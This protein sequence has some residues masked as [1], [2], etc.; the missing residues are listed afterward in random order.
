[1][2]TRNRTIRAV[3]RSE[4]E[5]QN[6]FSLRHFSR[7]CAES[8]NRAFFHLPA[9]RYSLEHIAEILYAGRKQTH[10]G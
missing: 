2:A 7:F 1:M 8:F 10:S 4:N 5:I 3:I 9:C 6:G